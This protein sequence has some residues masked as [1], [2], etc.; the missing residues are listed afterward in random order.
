MLDTTSKLLIITPADDKCDLKDC[1]AGDSVI[2]LSNL[3]S[4]LFHNFSLF[5]A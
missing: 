1:S 3:T 5:R 4:N 2:C